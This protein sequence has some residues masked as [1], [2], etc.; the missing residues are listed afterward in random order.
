MPARWRHVIIAVLLVM[1]VAVLGGPRTSGAPRTDVLIVA[2]DIS[3][4]RTPDPSKSYDISGV[5]LQFP[6]YS[7]LVRQRAP[8]FWKVDPDLAESWS[9]SSDARVYTFKLRSDAVFHA[10][11]P[12]TAEDVR[13]S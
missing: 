8:N 5:F 10:G 7:R 2:K 13:F 9:V 12:A 3:D 4:I 1:L 11:N 6:V